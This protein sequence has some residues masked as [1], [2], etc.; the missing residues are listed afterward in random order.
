VR[1]RRWTRLDYERVVDC[2]GF[3]PED[4]IEL[5]DGEL[6]EMSPQGSRHATAYSLTVDAVREAF[7]AGYHVRSQLPFALDD[8]S[9][10]EPD[11]AVVPGSPRNYRD[12]HPIAALL[13]VEVSQS[14]LSHDRG[15][16]MAAY[17][18][19][20]IAEYWILDL[21]VEKVEVYREPCGK[22]YRSKTIRGRGESIE[23]LHA[24]GATIAVDDLLP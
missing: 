24:A 1:R 8:V 16:K 10:P 18:R 21:T 17:A 13:I 15:R 11:I 2:G 7:G 12:G 6:W 22:S 9:E 5:L 4:R 3:G 14:T 19:N 23:P 20:G